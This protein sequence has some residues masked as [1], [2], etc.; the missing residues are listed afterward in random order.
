MRHISIVVFWDVVPYS[1]VD[2]HEILE[3]PAPSIFVVHFFTLADE[4][5]PS[6]RKNN[7]VSDFHIIRNIFHLQ[8]NRNF[9]QSQGRQNLHKRNAG[10]QDGRNIFHLQIRTNLSLYLQ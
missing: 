2:I 1:A 9:F 3:R 8:D 4:T 10:L 6:C 7:N 5:F